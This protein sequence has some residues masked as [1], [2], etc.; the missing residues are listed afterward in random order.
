ME[1]L[2]EFS[3][4]RVYKHMENNRPM[5]ILTGFRYKDEQGNV[6]TLSQNRARNNKIKAELQKM[7]FGYV[8]VKGAY[9]ERD[10]DTGEGVEVTEESLLV[11]GEVGKADELKAIA[12]K[13]GKKF[14]QDSIFFRD[15]KGQ[16]M[17]ISTRK[18]SFVGPIGS[19]DRLGRF[20]PKQI[21]DYYT[22]LKNTK[23]AF[24]FLNLTEEFESASH[25]GF[26]GFWGISNNRAKFMSESYEID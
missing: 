22:K 15:D 20:V 18:D 13:L 21:G 17:L 10:N 6:L 14:N 3:M 19:I 8:Q 4:G 1:Q 16:A 12:I 9:I 2:Q 23:G 24:T 25:V 7:N 5:A 26:M 11:M